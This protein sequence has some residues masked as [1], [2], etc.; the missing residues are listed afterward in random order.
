MFNTAY[1]ESGGTWNP[2]LT[3]K[4]GAQGL[5]Q[6]TH[7]TAD[8]LGVKNS[9]DLEQNI[10][11][12]TELMAKLLRITNGDPVRAAIGYNAGTAPM[13][14]RKPLATETRYHIAKI[15]GLNAQNLPEKVAVPVEY[16]MNPNAFYGKLYEK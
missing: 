9:F 1:K 6:L 13:M 12:G 16:P 15:F 5:L 3:S 2:N 11:G 4:A 7:G 10:K 8:S 14:G